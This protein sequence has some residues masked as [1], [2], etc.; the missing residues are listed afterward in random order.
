MA[1]DILLVNPLFLH[2]DPVEYRLMTP[3][4]PLGLLYLAATV[5]QVGYSVQIYDC[6]FR[7]S[8][9]EFASALDQ[10]QPRVVGLGILSTM[11]EMAQD[12]IDIAHQKGCTV[13][14][15]GADPTARAESYLERQ[16]GGQVD[17]AVV[18]EAE[19]TILDLLPGLLNR[20]G[21]MPRHEIRGIV[22]RDEMGAIVRTEPRPLRRQ[23]DEIAFPARDLIDVDAY[24][25]AWRQEHGFLS[26]SII[27]SRGCPYQCAWCQKSVFG[28]S[29]RLR[30]PENVAAEMR[31]I[32]T[33]Y[34]PDRIRLV[35]DVTGIN[36][37]WI[38]RWRD[39][40]LDRD[41]LIPFECL[42]RVDLVDRE[43]LTWLKE[44]GCVRIS[45]GAESGSQKVLDAMTKGTQVA[46]IY[47]AAELCH[48]L[49][50][51]LYFFI[52]VGYPTETWQDI[53]ATAK[54]LRE[55]MPDTFSSTIAYPLEGTPFYDQVR[56]RL[57]HDHDWSHT[58]EN[59]VLYKARYGTR[60]YRWVQRW[61]HQQWRWAR[62]RAGR[63]QPSW[64][65]KLRVLAARALSRLA[66]G[67]LRHLPADA[68]AVPVSTP[69]H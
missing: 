43:M 18:G 41:A 25:Q 14:V 31:E 15:G 68:R 33:R 38:R 4:F 9:S 20:P 57:I 32:K 10:I 6:M 44:A 29:F 60:F 26:L 24:R 65:G 39:A 53:Q 5:R 42:S 62:I 45:F 17:V 66:V 46:E 55:T 8:P 30:S 22:Y 59:R 21:A 58:A 3:Y 12:L 11:R 50:I 56:D 69:G 48:E 51:E 23:V 28:R 37:D 27:A 47:R 40:L 49:G 34:H 61:F 63:E 36:R 64:G 52:M 19:E 7:Q 2:R 16:T 1:I 54:L 13:M 67:L 35:D